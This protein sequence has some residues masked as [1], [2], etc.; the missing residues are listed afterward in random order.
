[1]NLCINYQLWAHLFIAQ[2]FPQSTDGG[3]LLM[4]HQRRRTHRLGRTHRRFICSTI[5]HCGVNVHASRNRVPS[6][7]EDI[8]NAS[9]ISCEKPTK[10]GQFRKTTAVAGRLQHYHQPIGWHSQSR[11]K[12]GL[13]TPAE[14]RSVSAAQQHRCTCRGPSGP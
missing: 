1:M 13:H 11:A 2:T 14:H 7:A 8:Y 12:R 9:T 5:S 3:A 4:A 10:H 6:A